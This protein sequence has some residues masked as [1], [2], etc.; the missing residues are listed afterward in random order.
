MCGRYARR[1]DKQKLSTYFHANPAPG[2]LDL[3][4]DYNV[5]PTTM[6]PVIRHARDGGTRELLLMRWGLVPFFAKSLADFKGY[7]TFNAKAESI[8]KTNTWREPF[9]RG[10]RCLVPI[11]GFYEWKVLGT[12]HLETGKLPKNAPKLPYIFTVGDGSPFA[13]AGLWDA[14]HDKANDQWLQSFT[15]ITTTPNALTAEVHTRMPVIL[16]PESYVEWLLREGPAPEH[17]LQPFP[18]DEMAMRPVSK[19]V[20]NVKNNHAGLLNSQ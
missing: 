12:D 13:L 4:P 11:D 19:D 1:S 17:L 20:G 5:A 14:W 15:V 10:R 18:A 7:S 2:L 3:P 16:H 9:T 6:Q 8:A